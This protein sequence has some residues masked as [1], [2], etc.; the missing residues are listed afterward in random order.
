MDKDERIESDRKLNEI[1][2]FN[3]HILRMQIQDDID[4]NGY[5]L[6]PVQGC[7]IA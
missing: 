6:K 2:R 3:A 4:R 1:Y 5:V 7:K